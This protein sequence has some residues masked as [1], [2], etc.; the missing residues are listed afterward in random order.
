MKTKTRCAWCEKDDLYRDYHDNVWGIPVHDE[1]I[2]FEYL[3]LEGA[4]AGLSWYTVLTKIEG[5]RDAFAQW[6]IE[7]IA[8]FSDKKKEKL[9]THPGIIKNRLKI[10]AV[11]SNAQLYLKM[12]SEGLT[13]KDYLWDYVDGKP[14]DNKYKKMSEVPA[15]TPLS[16]TISKDFKKRGFKFVGPTIVYAYMQAIGMVNDHVM[17]CWTRKR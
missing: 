10:N 7:K 16:Q 15:E 2:L 13:L 11:V 9:R 4:Q 3:N 14:I 6:D 8:K 12:R 17:S 1:K 5:Y